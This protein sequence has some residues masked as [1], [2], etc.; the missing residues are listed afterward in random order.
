VPSF[1]RA[2]QEWGRKVSAPSGRGITFQVWPPPASPLFETTDKQEQSS[3]LIG[4]LIGGMLLEHP[5]L[6]DK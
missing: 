6:M 3:L 1:P 4:D 2:P 5:R